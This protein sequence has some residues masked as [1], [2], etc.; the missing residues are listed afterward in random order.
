MST[1][2]RFIHPTALKALEQVYAHANLKP[3]LVQSQ[4]AASQS[5]GTHS[6][7]G[8]YKDSD[9]NWQSYSVCLDFSVRQSALRLTDKKKIAMDEAHIKWFLEIA[10]EFGLG[11]WYRTP[12]QGFDAA[13][14]HLICLMVPFKHPDPVA[15]EI[16]I[17]QAVDVVTDK[18]GLKGHKNETFW[19]A[20]SANDARNAKQFVKANPDARVL[21]PARLLTAK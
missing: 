9:G 14:L 18:T 2:T 21:V 17:H 15:R 8:K 6:S 12:S 11:G 10:S 4:G 1:S 3:V 16:C 19:H 5:A 13:H 20:S 7:A